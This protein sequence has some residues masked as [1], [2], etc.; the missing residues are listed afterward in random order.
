LIDLKNSVGLICSNESSSCF[1]TRWRG[2][3]LRVLDVVVAK[4]AMG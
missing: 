2:L 3:E 1:G 4:G